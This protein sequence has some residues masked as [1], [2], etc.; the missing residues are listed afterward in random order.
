MSWK[1]CQHPW[2]H[3]DS[4]GSNQFQQ[5]VACRLCDKVL[6]KAWPTQV[7]PE[8]LSKAVTRIMDIA[9]DP[10]P[11]RPAPPR[12]RTSEAATESKAPAKEKEV[13][14][15]ENHLQQKQHEHVLRLRGAT[16]HEAGTQTQTAE[17]EKRIVKRWKRLVIVAA[18]QSPGL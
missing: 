2:E 15:R 11:P 5:Q 1:A 8:L 10:A 12:A 17:M 4:N 16:S 13:H 18:S 14:A 6:F 3:Q 7:K 9:S